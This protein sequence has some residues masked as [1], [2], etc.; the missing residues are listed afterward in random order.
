MVRQLATL[1]VLA[2]PEDLW[3]QAL[4]LGQA[5]RASGSAPTSMDL[6]IA[7]I[8]LHHGAEVVTFDRDFL[9][10]AAVSALRVERLV[11]ADVPDR[12]A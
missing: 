4:Q 6:V 1:P 10:I 8:A 5:C 3:E 12:L 7:A 11:R 2:T 9:D